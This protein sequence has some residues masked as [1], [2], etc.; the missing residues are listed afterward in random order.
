MNTSMLCYS[1]VATYRILL[2]HNKFN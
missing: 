1:T 2:T